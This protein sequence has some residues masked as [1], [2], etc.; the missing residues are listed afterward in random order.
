MEKSF[1]INQPVVGFDA[2][3][4]GNKLRNMVNQYAKHEIDF[5]N[6]GIA[7]DNML[8]GSG[9]LETWIED[10]GG[11]QKIEFE[12]FR[13]PDLSTNTPLRLT[14]GFEGDGTGKSSRDFYISDPTVIQPGG[15][16]YKLM[17]E[18]L[19]LTEYAY[20]EILRQQYDIEGYDNVTVERYVNDMAI[21]DMI[22]AGGG[23]EEDVIRLQN[24][25]QDMLIQNILLH[26]EVEL[27]QFTNKLGQRGVQGDTGFVP[28]Q[29]IDRNTGQASFNQAAWIVLQNNP[30]Q[31]A[32][33]RQ[34]ILDMSMGEFAG[35]NF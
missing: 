11:S 17:D 28:F 3:E 14:F 10:G 25:K 9:D 21:K 4:Q 22:F 30:S 32:G 20:D 31:L 33:L 16:V 18:Q 6:A 1:V 23:S 8:P 13:M 12:G 5:N 27:P 26:P 24:E 35:Y 19:Q 2:S 7:S 34:R 15:W 29:M